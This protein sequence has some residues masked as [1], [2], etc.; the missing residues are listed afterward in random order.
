MS[1]EWSSFKNLP[2][3]PRDNFENLCRGIVRIHWGKFGH[4]QALKNQP[5]VEFHLKLD[6]NC[7]VLGNSGR[8]YGWQCKIFEKTST[9]D[10]K[11]VSKK[12]IED[13]LKKTVKA[14]PHLTDWILWVPF[15]LSKKD[16]EW[17]WSL[18]NQC[19]YKL[20]LWTDVEVDNYLSDP[21]L[22]LRQAYF[23]ELI[24]TPETLRKQHEIS[25]AP[26]KERWM[27]PVHQEVDVERILRRMLGEKSSLNDIV[28]LGQR[29]QNAANVIEKFSIGVEKLDKEQKIFAEI[30]SIFSKELF[31][32]HSLL[33]NADIDIIQQWLTERHALLG[34]D[35]LS[36]PGMLRRRNI[37]L[38]LE[39]TNALDDLRQAQVLFDEIADYLEIGMVAV[40]ADAGGGK[41]HMAAQLTAEQ[42]NR[43]A[44]ILL[45]GRNFR[46]GQNQDDIA[47]YFSINGTPINSME[48][49]LASLDAAGKR[50]HCRLPIVIDGL[51]EAENPKEWKDVLNSINE[52]IK[53]YPNVLLICTLRTGE[54]NRDHWQHTRYD[55]ETRESFAVQA[56][57]DN[58]EMLECQGFGDDLYPALKKYFKY[59]KIHCEQGTE[60]PGEFLNHPLNLRIFCE[61]INH[62]K[63]EVIHVDYIPATLSYLFDEYIRNACDR[64]SRL[65]NVPYTLQEI[66]DALYELGIILWEKND[67]EVSDKDFIGKIHPTD[68]DWNQNVVNLL[69]Q[70]GIVFRN[71]GAMPGTY[72]ITPVYDALGGHIIA[73]SLL[74]RETRDREFNWLVQAFSGGRFSGENSHALSNDIFKSLVALTP[75]R[76]YG[77]QLWK[78]VPDQYKATALIFTMD[79]DPKYIDQDTVNQLT[80]LI[81]S[82]DYRH[83][84]F[85]RLWMT[86][87]A[88]D[89][90]LN[91]EFLDKILRNMQVDQRDLTWTEWI[92]RDHDISKGK[93]ESALSN[94]ESKW[95]EN[96]TS[97]T[98]SD[99]LRA[100]AF[101]WILTST[102][103]PL[104]NAATKTLYWFGRGSPEALFDLT[105]KSLSINDPYVSERLL[106]ASYGVSVSLCNR[107]D[108]N[109]SFVNGVLTKFAGEIFQNVF[110]P[111]AK[112]KTTHQFSR[113]F[114]SRIIELT[115]YHNPNYF[116]ESDIKKTRYPFSIEG[117][118]EWGEKY[119][120]EDIKI[121]RKLGKKSATP[122]KDQEAKPKKYELSPFYM[123]FENYTIGR[124]VPDRNNY[125]Y[126]NEEYKKIKA[127][128]LWRVYQLG[129]S[130]E[131]FKAVDES[132][133]GMQRYERNG[134][135]KLKTDRY[136]KK[137]SWISY[138][139]MSG[140][141]RDKGALEESDWWR[142]ETENIDPSFLPSPESSKLINTNF[143][144]NDSVSTQEWIGNNELPDVV[145][146]LKCNL[147]KISE[148]SWIALDGN[149]NQENRDLGRSTFFFIRSFLVRNEDREKIT[150]H[151]KRNDF[152]GSRLPEKSDLYNT[153]WCEIPW[154]EAFTDG[155]S[156]ELSFVATEKKLIKKRPK[157]E[158]VRSNEGIQ[159][160]QGE[161]EEY[162][163]IDYE[164]DLFNVIN[165]TCDL[166]RD[167]TDGSLGNVASLTKKLALKMEL[168]GQPQSSDLYTKEG[169][170]ATHYTTYNLDGYKNSHSLFYVQEHL[171]KKFIKEQ[172]LSLIWFIWG[173]KNYAFT[174]PHYDRKDLPEP[175]Y[176]SFHE[177]KVYE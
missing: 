28:D 35:S 82:K 43:P 119:I 33:S 55:S 11:S 32:F 75:N 69:A 160:I 118:S 4:F 89:H 104:R 167:A 22:L 1:L 17:F 143:L 29:L 148:N 65:K 63:L 92:R 97:R 141:L 170:P 56:L 34:N 149:I 40:L 84:I 10:L 7:P 81:E 49:L 117:L 150:T 41:T 78:K 83:R 120:D 90:P 71:P 60:I 145:P 38:A 23:G 91:A 16:Q 96:F 128:L 12:D 57:P 18:K 48:K 8:W 147:P 24:I 161:I 44:G 80:I 122:K 15:N 157:L 13:S 101:S 98:A 134:N 36:F 27:H 42:E 5:G 9:E 79:L 62:K 138:Y 59:Y 151:L 121:S 14:L 156:C 146:Y 3:S 67:R 53:N 130:Y 72:V 176:T 166:R 173:E 171:L 126:D 37:S 139:E 109:A 68:R 73:A 39:A 106:A 54:H 152:K 66:S 30:C 19:P 114:S 177:V 88:T 158:I 168:V 74:K 129:W 159:L 172:G 64:I 95:K 87:G 100:K 102:S 6:Q 127:Q 144:G 50:S 20:H 110:S 115:Q 113:D 61:I 58:L 125:D 133:A 112:Y 136:G 46:R 131:K 77:E 94:L 26:I 51:N 86:K 108:R 140:R 163:G 21:A 132:I 111:E 165:P 45:H 137:Y 135:E 47:R 142:T 169:Q 2:G 154:S 123:D 162:E 116:S 174:A 107:F 105:I 70:E 99:F 153:F 155:S 85:E 52:L 103:H 25:I 124:L 31:Q 93:I 76:M 164:Y 175:R